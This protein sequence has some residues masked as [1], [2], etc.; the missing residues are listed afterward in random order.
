MKFAFKKDEKDPKF[1][2]R[3]SG[4]LPAYAHIHIHT[5]Y[6]DSMYFSYSVIFQG[7]YLLF[8]MLYQDNYRLFTFS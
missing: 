2:I 5:W 3:W 1:L 7:Q 8:P 4:C 6:Q